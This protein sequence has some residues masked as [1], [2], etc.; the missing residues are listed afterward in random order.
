MI[1]LSAV[2]VAV[3]VGAGVYLLLSPDVQRV[4]LGF[5]LLS[6]AVNLLVLTG[7]PPLPAASAPIVGAGAGPAAD[8][9]PQAFLLTAIVI[10]L[11][12]AGF[13]LAMAVRTYRQTGSDELED[14]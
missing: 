1:A 13:L 2:C 4:V 5:L 14:R 6:N 9:L 12:A 8:P 3:L 10:G 11:A 7:S